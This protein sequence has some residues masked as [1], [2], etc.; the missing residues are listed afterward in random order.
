[1]VGL[2]SIIILS[3]QKDFIN[4]QMLVSLLSLLEVSIIIIAVLSIIKTVIRYK[5]EN[6]H[7]DQS[8]MV[9]V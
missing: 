9:K 2:S 6:K 5:K 1:M 4:H 3:S 7:R 8:F